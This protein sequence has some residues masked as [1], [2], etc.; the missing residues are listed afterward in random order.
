MVSDTV[1]AGGREADVGVDDE[2]HEIVVRR[3]ALARRLREPSCRR[4]AGDEQVRVDDRRLDRRA[5]VEPSRCVDEAFMVKAGLE[6]IE[7]CREGGHRCLYSP[8]RYVTASATN[9]AMSARM[10][11]RSSRDI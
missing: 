7:S 4:E 5:A 3:P 8:Q 1:S 9:P 6:V 2:F 11:F 10:G